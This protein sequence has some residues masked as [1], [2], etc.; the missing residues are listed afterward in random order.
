MTL[1]FS[2]KSLEKYSNIKFHEKPSVA[3]VLLQANRRRDMTKLMVGFRS[4]A[5]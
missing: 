5:N 4:F 1:E 3:T 2:R